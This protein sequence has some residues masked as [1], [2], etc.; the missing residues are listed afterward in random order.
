VRGIT[1]NISAK[2]RWWSVLWHWILPF[3][4]SFQYVLSTEVAALGLQR[5]DDLEHY[6]WAAEMTALA[7]EQSLFLLIEFQTGRI[8]A[9]LSHVQVDALGNIVLQ[10]E[11]APGYPD[12][13]DIHVEVPPT[14]IVVYTKAWDGKGGIR[15]SAETAIPCKDC[16]HQSHA[17]HVS[18]RHDLLAAEEDAAE[19]GFL[20]Q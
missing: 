9:K 3:V 15:L 20:L 14:G 4:Y 18:N 5:N 7:K 2:I 13:T 11:S 17:V 10:Q 12:A 19:T 16:L 6:A 8:R 1:S